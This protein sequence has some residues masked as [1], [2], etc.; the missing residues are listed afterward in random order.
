M[1]VAI[2]LFFFG[3][4]PLE[5]TNPWVAQDWENKYIHIKLAMIMLAKVRMP[6]W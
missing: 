2:V 6:F 5:V 1:L 3:L 4:S